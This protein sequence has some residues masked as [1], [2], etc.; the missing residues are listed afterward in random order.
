MENKPIDFSFCKGVTALVTLGEGIEKG[1]NCLL[2]YTFSSHY[3]LMETCEPETLE[4]Q[5][6]YVVQRRLAHLK[7][8]LC[9]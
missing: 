7:S 1:G 8:S 6:A 5:L 4:E 3:S 2:G 9:F